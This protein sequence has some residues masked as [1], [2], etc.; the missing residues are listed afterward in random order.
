[1][2]VRRRLPSAPPLKSW[3]GLMRWAIERRTAQNSCRRRRTKFAL[4]PPLNDDTSLRRPE[5]GSL[6]TS[7]APP[8]ERLDQEFQRAVDLIETFHTLPLING[9]CA[10]WK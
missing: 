9:K 7:R 8:G 2:F 5:P 3:T 4:G 6:F 10:P 1:M